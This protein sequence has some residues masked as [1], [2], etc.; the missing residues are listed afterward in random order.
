VDTLE[1][2]MSMFASQSLGFHDDLP[3]RRLDPGGVRSRETVKRSAHG[4]AAD[5]GYCRSHSRF[6]WGSGCTASSLPIAPQGDHG[7]LPEQDERE[8]ALAFALSLIIQI[9]ERVFSV[10]PAAMDKGC[11]KN[12]TYNGCEERR[13]ARS[14]C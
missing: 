13:Y 9:V 4:D 3:A 8:V 14:S 5:Y 12:R 6:F 2:L 11:D 1:L 10:R 7:R